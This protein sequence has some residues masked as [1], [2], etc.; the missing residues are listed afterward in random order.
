VNIVFLSHDRIVTN[1]RQAICSAKPCM[2]YT[3]RHRIAVYSQMIAT[4][5]LIQQH[6]RRRIRECCSTDWS[7]AAAVIRPVPFAGGAC[8]LLVMY[9]CRLSIDSNESSRFIHLSWA[10]KV[11]FIPLLDL[12][13]RRKVRTRCSFKLF[14]TNQLEEN[15]SFF[16]LAQNTKF[17]ATAQWAHTHIVSW[18]FLL[19]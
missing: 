7:T 12:K 14:G 10:N 3:W 16:K 9:E 18:N 5:L 19:Y 15:S 11:A 13:V 8:G 2:L 1:L 4:R 6:N 17:T